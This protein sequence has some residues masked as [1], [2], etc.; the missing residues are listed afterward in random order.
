MTN[1]MT[2]PVVMHGAQDLHPRRLLGHLQHL[3]ATNTINPVVE[4]T[5]TQILTVAQVV[6]AKNLV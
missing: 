6:G 3:K 1:L 2:G 5:P 4:V